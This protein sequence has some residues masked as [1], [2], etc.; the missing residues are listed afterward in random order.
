MGKEERRKSWKTGRNAM[1]LT[2]TN[3]QVSPPSFIRDLKWICDSPYEKQTN[4]MISNYNPA[5]RITD[6]HALVFY[7]DTWCGLWCLTLSECFS[8]VSGSVNRTSIMPVQAIVKGYLKSEIYHFIIIQIWYDDARYL[9]SAS[10]WSNNCQ[11]IQGR[12]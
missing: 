2:T 11:L 3:S 1:S 4:A 5:G 8:L 12:Y 7:R 9:K 10:I 6:M